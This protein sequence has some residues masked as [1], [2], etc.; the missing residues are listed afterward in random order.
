MQQTAV[1]VTQSE[2]SPPTLAAQLLLGVEGQESSPAV[3]RMRRTS[4][5][6]IDRNQCISVSCSRELFF[7]DYD[8][9]TRLVTEHP[10][11]PSTVPFVAVELGL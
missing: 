2:R 10:R 9:P 8:D 7:P 3:P 11:H 1:L 6:A 5:Q 4:V